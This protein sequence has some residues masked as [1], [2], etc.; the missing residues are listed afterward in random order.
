M[1]DSVVVFEGA[2]V[3]VS[4]I[5]FIDVCDI[6]DDLEYVAEALEL[7]DIRVENEIVEV[8]D[9]VLDPCD[10]RDLVGEDVDDLLV[11]VEAV[12]VRVFAMVFVEIEDAVVVFDGADEYDFSGDNVVVF[13][14]T[15]ERVL[16]FVDV[17]VIV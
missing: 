6:S 1:D 3:R 7:L 9:P 8:D 4:V 10:D 5:D 17:A 13:D 14:D 2:I 11:V 15:V 16:V 12:E